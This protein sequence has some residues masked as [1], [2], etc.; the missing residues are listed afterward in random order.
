MCEMERHIFSQREHAVFLRIESIS[1]LLSLSP[2]GKMEEFPDY[3]TRMLD[4]ITRCDTRFGTRNNN[5]T[6][7][8][9]VSGIRIEKSTFDRCKLIFKLLVSFCN[10]DV[11]QIEI[12]ST[13]CNWYF[14]VDSSSAKFAKFNLK[15][16]YPKTNFK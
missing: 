2:K 1:V 7:S 13:S 10:T 11:T 9:Q 4:S 12:I 5:K 14:S 3:A 15:I 16:F 8:L 6:I